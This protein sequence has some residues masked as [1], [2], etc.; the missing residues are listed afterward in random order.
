MEICDLHEHFVIFVENSGVPDY[1]LHFSKT[2]HILVY[3]CPLAAG[4]PTPLGV[5][6]RI[7]HTF[8]IFTNFLQK[9]AQGHAALATWS[10]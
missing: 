7:C 2:C 1:P 4:L 6:G 10:T 9:A 8:S 3:V 5:P